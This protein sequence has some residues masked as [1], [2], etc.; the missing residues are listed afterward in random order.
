METTFGRP[1]YIFPS[2]KEVIKEV[3]DYIKNNDKV[4]I[5]TTDSGF[6]KP[7]ELC[8]AFDKA[9]IQFKT[10]EWTKR[11]NKYLNLKFKNLN[12]KSNIIITSKYESYTY[13]SDYKRVFL[14]GWVKQGFW[15]VNS[16]EKGFVYSSHADYPSL[17]EFVRKCNPEMVYTHHGYAEE[18]A[19]DLR[20][21][22][23][24]AKPL[25]SLTF[26]KKS[27]GNYQSKLFDFS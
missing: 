11:I 23:F 24:N 10:N 12:E 6:G 18:F 7:Q 25:H 22:G 13:P 21:L 3:V 27:G 9:G 19:R 16:Y 20:K 5:T 26:K 4:L 17:I 1:N 2:K 14:S 8:T 15:K